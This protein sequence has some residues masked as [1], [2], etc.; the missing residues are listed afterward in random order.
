[1]L[2]EASLDSLSCTLGGTGL[3]RAGTVLA[4]GGLLART[5]KERARTTNRVYSTYLFDRPS[6]FFLAGQDRT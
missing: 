2:F 6:L 1:M 3:G 4:R 5:N